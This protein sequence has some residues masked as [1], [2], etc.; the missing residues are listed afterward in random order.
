M[1]HAS[2]L[3]AVVILAG[4]AEAAGPS[5]PPPRVPAT[6]APPPAVVPITGAFVWGVVVDPSGACL[7]K[8][9][10]HVMSGPGAGQSA[11]Q[12]TPCGVWD[13]EGG[14]A[15]GSLTSGVAMTIRASAPGYVAQEVTVVP[16][17][18]PLTATVIVLERAGS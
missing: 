14:F 6:P 2:R 4:C 12:V 18:G 8:A 3:L 7:A 10:V 1:R 9:T 15:F 5:D 16:D 17:R 13:D 11:E